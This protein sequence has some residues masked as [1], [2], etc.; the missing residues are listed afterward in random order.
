MEFLD[1]DLAGDVFPRVPVRDIRVTKGQADWPRIH[2]R[3]SIE[4]D[5]QVI[6]SVEQKLAD[7]NYQLGVNMYQQD[8]YGYEKQMLDNWFRKE[9]L[10]PKKQ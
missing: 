9:I 2:V 3:Y 5:G 6:R 1:I 8:L 7:P 10:P 4:Q